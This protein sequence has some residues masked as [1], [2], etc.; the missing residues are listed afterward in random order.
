MTTFRS[1]ECYDGFYDII[2]ELAEPELSPEKISPNVEVSLHTPNG[3]YTTTLFAHTDTPKKTAIY[4]DE[5]YTMVNDP[6]MVSRMRM[7]TGTVSNWIHVPTEFANA[8]VR[9]ISLPS[10]IAEVTIFDYKKLIERFDPTHFIYIPRHNSK[11][12][13]GPDWLLETREF[14]TLLMGRPL[15]RAYTLQSGIKHILNAETVVSDAIDTVEITLSNIY[16]SYAPVTNT[17]VTV[18]SNCR[19]SKDKLECSLEPGKKYT[20]KVLPR[21]D[22]T[23]KIGD[24]SHTIPIEPPK[25][26]PTITA[27]HE[28][29]RVCLMRD[30]DKNP[31][32]LKAIEHIM[33]IFSQIGPT[34][35]QHYAPC[36]IRAES[37]STSFGR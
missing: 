5:V 34:N 28:I 6:G 16:A 36:I 15:L 4:G 12:G 29:A 25:S 8:D 10:D 1:K 30:D 31:V 11:H 35:K 14:R 24:V 26:D 3:K 19:H 2:V 13:L 18:T 33:T 23:L 22:L 20:F 7:N 32:Q 17:P 37:S 27:M 9:I 21:G